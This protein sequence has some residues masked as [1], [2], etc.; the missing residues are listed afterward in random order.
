MW[1][2]LTS[3]CVAK[4]AR[5]LVSLFSICWRLTVPCI[6]VHPSDCDLRSAPSMLNFL[7]CAT[8][9]V[10]VFSV[11]SLVHA[12]QTILA[13]HSWSLC[14]CSSE[15]SCPT[16]LMRLHSTWSSSGSVCALTWQIRDVCRFPL[17]EFHALQLGT[18]RQWLHT[19]ECMQIVTWRRRNEHEV[20]FFL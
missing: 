14:P 9:T 18:L 12:D 7:P 17:V 4:S 1:F 11:S 20:F 10:C 5:N 16:V 15:L 13:R 19:A 2:A 8:G 6:L 3:G